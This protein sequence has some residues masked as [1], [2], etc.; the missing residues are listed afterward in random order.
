MSALST[1]ISV[2]KHVALQWPYMRAVLSQVA[3]NS[4]VCSAVCLGWYKREDQS[5]TLLT[6]ATGM[7]GGLSS[8][9]SGIRKLC[10][11]VIMSC[12]R[13]VNS[14]R[15]GSCSLDSQVLWIPIEIGPYTV[16]V[17]AAYSRMGKTGTSGRG[18]VSV[19][20]TMYSPISITRHDTPDISR[21]PTDFQ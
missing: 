9:R 14:L 12:Q 21:G 11:D 15:C 4:A 6:L 16:Y 1:D 19:R 7:A 18:S 20:V 8:Q 17:P 5:F 10:H 3:G 2:V 13:A